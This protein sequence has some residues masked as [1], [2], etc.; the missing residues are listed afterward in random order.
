MKPTERIALQA[1][2]YWGGSRYAYTENDD[3]QRLDDLHL[4]SATCSYKINAQ[5]GA[6][7]SVWNLLN[8]RTEVWNRYASYGT[9]GVVGVSFSF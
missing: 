1:E 2:Y 6:F 8:R 7:A 3:C 5:I 9:T 4:L